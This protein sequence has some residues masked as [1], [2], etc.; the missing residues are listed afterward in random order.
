MI[1]NSGTPRPP[2]RLVSRSC[3]PGAASRRFTF[4]FGRVE[5]L[6]GLAVVLTITASAAVAAYEAIQRLVHRN[7]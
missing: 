7:R 1:H 2:F 4:G 3:T 5:D 6:A